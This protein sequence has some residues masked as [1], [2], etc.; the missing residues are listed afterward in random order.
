[1]RR[2]LVPWLFLMLAACASQTSGGSQSSG[3]NWGFGLDKS[4]ENWLD[5]NMGLGYYAL[6]SWAQGYLHAQVEIL[7]AQQKLTTDPMKS[8]QEK[9]LASRLNT[10]CNANPRG[11]MPPA[12]QA[13]AKELVAQAK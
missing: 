12:L 3:Q 2:L 7:M 9:Q 5:N 11:N 10:Y 8:L 6:I 4:C 13:Y 1:M